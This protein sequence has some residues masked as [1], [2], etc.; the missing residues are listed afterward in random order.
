MGTLDHVLW[1]APDLEPATELLA[2]VLG[3]K[4]ACGGSHPGFGSRNQLLSLGDNLFFEVIAPDPAQSDFGRR[5]AEIAD[6]A[7]PEMHTFCIAAADLAVMEKK[8]EAIGIPVKQP[9]AMSRTR[10]DGVKL[11]WRILYFDAPEWGGALPFVIDWQGSPHP[12]GNSPKGCRLKSFTVLHPRARE[13]RDIYNAI[14][15][16]V[17]TAA[18]PL[19]G[20]L[21]RLDTP[22][23]E[24]VLT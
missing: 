8:A 10:S 14:G 7:K 23:G 20:F 24:V 15:I 2:G 9:V 18:A 19:P 22:N 16:D 4:P 17:D 5:A 21:L 12:A 3:V 6:L 13:L 11:E 1:A